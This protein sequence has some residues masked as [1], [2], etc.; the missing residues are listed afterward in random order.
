MKIKTESIKLIPEIENMERIICVEVSD[1]YCIFPGAWV[2]L[3][4]RASK[5][6]LSGKLEDVMQNGFI[7]AKDGSIMHLLENE[8]DFLESVKVFF[9]EVKEKEISK[10]WPQH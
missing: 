4:I 8:K 1:Q 5:T 3:N 9:L 2:W 10:L 7:T 6:L